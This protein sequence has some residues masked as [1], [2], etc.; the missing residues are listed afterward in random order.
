MR[1][2]RSIWRAMKWPEFLLFASDA[3]RFVLAGAALLLLSA[4]ATLGERRRARR[5]HPDA[6]GIM[7]WRDIGVLSALAGLA[8]CGF[9][10]VGWL[11]G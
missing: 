10:I 4:V 8:L 5:K 7:P 3:T 1:W 9:G 6:V 11:Q 2:R